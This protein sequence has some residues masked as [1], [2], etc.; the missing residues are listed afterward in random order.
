MWW[1]NAWLKRDKATLEWLERNRWKKHSP[2]K[3]GQRVRAACLIEWSDYSSRFVA[4]GT[5]GVIVAVSETNDSEYGVKWNGKKSV[6]WCV[7]N[8]DAHFEED[9][10]SFD[11]E[12]AVIE[13]PVP[14]NDPSLYVA[15][16][17]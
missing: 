14:D 6:W 2:L 17:L 12:I 9:G 3:I 11:T 15:T 1:G 8:P 10:F 5:E 13:V 7:W 4:E 16:L